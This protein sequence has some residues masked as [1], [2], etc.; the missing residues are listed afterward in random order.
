MTNEELERLTKENSEL[1]NLNETLMKKLKVYE[2]FSRCRLNYFD[3]SRFNQYKVKNSIEQILGA[4]SLNSL[5][6]KSNILY[7]AG[8]PVF[9]GI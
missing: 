4:I 6:Y 3:L 9:F 2:P 1:K 5:K 8:Y 7:R